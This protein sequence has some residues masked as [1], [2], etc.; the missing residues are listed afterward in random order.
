[1]FRKCCMALGVVALSFFLF[2]ARSTDVS[3]QYEPLRAE[4]DAL[5]AQD[6]LAYHYD[7]GYDGSREAG[8]V[9]YAGGNWYCATNRYTTNEYLGYEGAYYVRNRD[10][11][12]TSAGSDAWF[13]VPPDTPGYNCEERTGLYDLVS[14]L[15]EAG[16]LNKVETNGAQ[17]IFSYS[18]AALKAL[19]EA[20]IERLE[21][22][23]AQTP[24][25]EDPFVRDSIQKWLDMARHTAFTGGTLTINKNGDG[26]NSIRLELIVEANEFDLDRDGNFIWSDKK[27]STVYES[28]VTVIGLAPDVIRRQIADAAALPMLPAE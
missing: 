2:T 16:D 10:P 14:H 4:I 9:R 15:P 18:R 27:E 28:S 19:Q 13:A 23:A 5:C 7:M 25:D 8:D 22:L 11:Q 26:L 21:T 20:E 12:F 24:E 1:M 17:T 3:A 6:T